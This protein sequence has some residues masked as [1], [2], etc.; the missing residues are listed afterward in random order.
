MS[1]TKRLWDALR[2]SR[3]SKVA[4]FCPHAGVIS[5]A[6]NAYDRQTRQMLAQRLRVSAWILLLATTAVL[7]RNLFT[8]NPVELAN[9]FGRAMHAT[10]IAVLAVSVVIL[11]TRCPTC[12]IRLRALELL[13]FGVPALVIAYVHFTRL[14]TT[15]ATS[16]AEAAALVG[17]ILIPWLLFMQVYGI[18]I[19]NRSWRAV[20][21]ISCLGAI[22]LAAL[23]VE[24]NQNEFMHT[25]LLVENRL[26]AI[27]IWIGIAIATASYGAWRLGNL[28]REAAEARQI[29][30][31]VLRQLLGRGGM[32][33]VYLA[34][35]KLL[36]R[37][38][39]IKL[40]RSDQSNERSVARFESEVQAAAQLT[41]P[42]TISIFDYGATDDGTFYYVMEYLPGLSLEDVVGRYGPLPPERVIHLLQQVCSALEEAH[43]SG[44]IHRD[45]KPANIMASERGGL[46]DFAKLLDFGL[47]KTVEQDD[48]SLKL[49]MENT[50]VGSPLYSPPETIESRSLDARSDIYSLGATAFY[51]L[52]G[53][54]VFE[55][56]T[57]LKVLFAHANEPAP[58]LRTIDPDLPPDLC[59]IVARCLAKD[60]EQRF[61]SAADLGEA[62]GLCASAQLWTQRQAQEWWQSTP[63]EESGESSEQTPYDETMVIGN[64]RSER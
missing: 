33:E 49:T 52:S 6:G 28:S 15:P 9:T 26:S 40:I 53:R 23:V 43:Q 1:V 21:V 22:P 62:L 57:S 14:H 24:A 7:L 8:G 54:P 18:S 11:S 50:V 17:E 29:E 51:L 38:A 48:T 63:D 32:G 35:H 30:M 19:P 56:E 42:N 41:H 36:K 20:L 4:D 46:Y 61:Q 5:E 59:D 27:L 34:E 44:L 10:V 13:V 64:D 58:D 2:E 16:T 31:Y 55:R 39:A 25:A 60:P 12:I 37:P 47:V 3:V 45:I